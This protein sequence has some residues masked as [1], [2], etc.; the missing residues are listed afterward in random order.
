MGVKLGKFRKGRT[1]QNRHCSHWL[2][3]DCFVASLLAM[4]VNFTKYCVIASLTKEGEAIPN[5]HS[6]N[7]LTVIA[8]KQPLLLP[9]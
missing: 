1:V 9:D 4:T 7:Q 3:E 2:L 8:A 6:K 5:S